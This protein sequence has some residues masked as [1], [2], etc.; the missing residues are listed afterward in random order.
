MEIS[1]RINKLDAESMELLATELESALSKA[2]QHQRERVVLSENDGRT[3]A[4]APALEA[5]QVQRAELE[6][7]L[8]LLTR[9]NVSSSFKRIQEINKELKELS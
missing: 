3:E 7:E 5:R 1:E 8:D 6:F 4:R 9:G 2:E